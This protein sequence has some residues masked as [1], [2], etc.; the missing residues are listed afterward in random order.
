MSVER[1]GNQG[2]ERV[3][4][5][6]TAAIPPAAGRPPESRAAPPHPR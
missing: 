3:R 6:S 5:G 1:F 2:V 4:A